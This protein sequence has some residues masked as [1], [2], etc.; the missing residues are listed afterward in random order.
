[1]NFFKIIN[2]IIIL[3]TCNF[4]GKAQNKTQ[5]LVTSGGDEFKGENISLEWSLG[6]IMTETFEGEYYT[7]TQGFNQAIYTI[8]SVKCKR[9]YQNIA[10]YPNP[11]RDHFFVDLKMEE[12]IKYSLRI[13][14]I[15]GKIVHVDQL[16]NHA[17]KIDIQFL[18]SNMYIVQILNNKN[19]I[20]KTFKLEKVR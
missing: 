4:F 2:I 20:I 18:K 6:E 1:M 19:R 14:D 13:I 9:K 8:T 16:T 3:I 17:N 12:D 7:L 10:V 5:E 11:C 15:I